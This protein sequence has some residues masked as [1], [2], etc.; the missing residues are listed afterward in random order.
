MVAASAGDL[1]RAATGSEP[2]GPISD[3]VSA[4]AI[5]TPFP[6]KMSTTQLPF[7]MLA[8]S[9]R[10]TT[11]LALGVARCKEQ[12]NC[13]PSASEYQC[14]GSQTAWTTEQFAW[15]CLH[16]A[17]GCT[18][19]PYAVSPL[20]SQDRGGVMHTSTTPLNF[21]CFKGSPWTWD[22]KKADWCCELKGVG[23]FSQRTTTTTTTTEEP[24]DCDV[25]FE[26]F[27][28]LWPPE[29]LVWCCWNKGKG[30]VG[31]LRPSETP[32]TTT[33][34]APITFITTP[35]SMNCSEEVGQWEEAWSGHKKLWCCLHKGVGCETA[36]RSSGFGGFPSVGVGSKFT[37]TQPSLR[38]QLS[39]GGRLAR[40]LHA[41][42]SAV[43]LFGVALVA[44][45]LSWHRQRRSDQPLALPL[46]TA[47]LL[48]AEADDHLGPGSARSMRRSSDEAL[49]E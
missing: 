48:A 46:Q 15:C 39:R 27:R 34:A 21:D 29:K 6:S 44:V 26:Y 2:T 12:G 35:R 37:A 11:T 36:T 16:R 1:V 20:L 13:P 47:G 40:V 18:T 14:D 33:T 28:V 3:R 5:T 7:K 4:E 31:N 23:C 10:S 45:L 19:T 22:K 32:S 24:F 41:P 30:C 38:A 49:L 17:K 25:D 8:A 43:A 42:A 9:T